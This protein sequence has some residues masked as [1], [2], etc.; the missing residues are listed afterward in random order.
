VNEIT[1]CRYEDFV[2]ALA[3]ETRQAILELLVDREMSVGEIVAR[4]RQTQP[5]I[6]HHL[7]LLRRAGLELAR[8]EG[9]RVY[10]SA[11][12]CCLQACARRLVE[13]WTGEEPHH[14]RDHHGPG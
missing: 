9:Q 6:S 5:T 4:F 14:A 7:G 2:K 10:Y 13:Q 1:C 3:D 8:R 11:N 12:R